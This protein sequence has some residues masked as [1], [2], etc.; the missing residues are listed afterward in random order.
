MKT[1]EIKSILVPIDFSPVANNAMETAIA[2]CKRQLAT[3]TLI[4]VVEN[5]YVL[6]PPE[7]GGA[8][9][10]ILPEMIKQ[11]NEGL[12]KLAK[13][14]RLDHD[15][16]VNHIVQSGNPADEICRWALHKEIDLIVL[17]THGAS[18]LREFFIGSNAY[19]VVKNSSCPVMT[20]P[21]FNQWL[22]FKKILF[23]IRMV[24]NALDKYDV[25]RPI[26]RKNGSLLQVAGI[27]KKN[28][29]TGILEMKA[30][31]DTVQNKIM[32]DDII[33]ESEVHYCDNVARQ[34]LAIANDKK[35]DLIVIT[36]TLDS[37]I[38][39]F[40]LGPY[41]QD[42]VNHAAFPVLSIRPEQIKH[43]A[44][45]LQGLLQGYPINHE[46]YA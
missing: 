27:V 18:G 4:H 40:F 1:Y 46:A 12:S 38:R 43:S 41:T 19:R 22:D 42:I 10:S 2:I 29:T 11:A 25:V 35:P 28:D 5:T 26:I 9:G 7:A 13:K 37:S 16:V 36:A 44:S 3:L 20:I 21:G 32:E 14:I 8:T 30:L 31:V 33:C 23:P 15:L 24:P 34:V 6:Y 17:G 45:T 39:D